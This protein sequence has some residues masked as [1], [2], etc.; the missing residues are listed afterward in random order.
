MRKRELNKIARDCFNE[1]IKSLAPGETSH[2]NH[3]GCPAGE[4]TRGR[5]Y[6]TRKNNPTE[7]VVWFCHNCTEGGAFN[8]TGRA[9]LAPRSKPTKGNELQHIM[10]VMRR[11]VDVTKLVGH[12]LT[13][14]Q[15]RWL[16]AGQPMWY[17][18][19]YPEDTI[20]Y[21]P[22]D[23]SIVF[24]IWT[25]N[26]EQD[27][28]PLPLAIQKRYH[29]EYG[30]KCIT[31]KANEGVSVRTFLSVGGGEG[32][33]VVVVEDMLSGLRI[34]R[35]TGYTAYVLFGN[36]MDMT[37]MVQHKDKFKDGLIV[38]LD[39]DNDQVLENAAKIHKRAEMLGLKT[40]R[41]DVKEEP[42]GLTIPALQCILGDEQ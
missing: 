16:N 38:W 36:H 1:H 24:P 28:M 26:P 25:T 8:T 30:P 39:N 14:D 23:Q 17:W 37:E 31:T 2:C 32:K 29:R 33:P 21:D 9:K 5:L 27:T 12:P 34:V 40:T 10:D 22:V 42:K 7:L 3:E 41:V 20:L 15:Q 13:L 35:D 18:A 19:Y 6:F 11:S 4:D